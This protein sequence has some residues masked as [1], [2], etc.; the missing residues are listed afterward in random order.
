MAE[1]LFF[2]LVFVICIRTLRRVWHL[3][4][5]ELSA[6]GYFV[7]VG[8]QRTARGIMAAAP[9]L[10]LTSLV[11]TLDGLVL[12]VFGVPRSVGLAVAIVSFVVVLLTLAAV[13]LGRPRFL[14]LPAVRSRAVY[15]RLIVGE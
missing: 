12:D 9:G 3:S 4:A 10:F 1:S 14:L 2:G 7:V 5:E 11:F 13:S 6:T 15:R 8:N